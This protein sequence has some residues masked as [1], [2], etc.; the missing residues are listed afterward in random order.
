M[1]DR[2]LLLVLMTKKEAIRLANSKPRNRKLQYYVIKWNGEYAI[3]PSSYIERN[4]DVEYVYVTSG[5]NEALI[6]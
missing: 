3:A 2:T 6:K 4:P 5:M 1:R